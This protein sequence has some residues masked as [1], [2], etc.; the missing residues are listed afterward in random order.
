L[1]FLFA[2]SS[3]DT[4]RARNSPSESQRKWF[5]FTWEVSVQK[6]HVSAHGLTIAIN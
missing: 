4:A 6:A 2:K 5:S 1:E 3:I